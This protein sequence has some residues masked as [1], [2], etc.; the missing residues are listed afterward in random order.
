[1]WDFDLPLGAWLRDRN[2]AAL[3]ALVDH[4][5]RDGNLPRHVPLHRDAGA[6][7]SLD[8]DAVLRCLALT[9]LKLGWLVSQKDDIYF[10]L[11]S[12]HA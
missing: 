8:V 12:F 6:V 4:R 5:A 9:R 1:M 11:N 3:G 7:G 2:H 10:S